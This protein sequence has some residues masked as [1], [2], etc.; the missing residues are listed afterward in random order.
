MSFQFFILI[1][2]AVISHLMI[3]IIVNVYSVYVECIVVGN[4]Q[5]ST[6]LMRT[7]IL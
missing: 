4:L 6:N 2:D 7:Q 3:I 1:N 5:L